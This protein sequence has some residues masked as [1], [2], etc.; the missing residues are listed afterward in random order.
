MSE[1]AA[2]LILLTFSVSPLTY[3]FNKQWTKS[4][5]PDFSV[6]KR[7]N[8][9]HLNIASG[10]LKN[11]WKG[12]LC[13]WRRLQYQTNVLKGIFHSTHQCSLHWEHCYISLSMGL[14]C[15]SEKAVD[16]MAVWT[17]CIWSSVPLE[18]QLTRIR[19]DTVLSRPQLLSSG[20]LSV[21]NC[22]MTAKH[23]LTVDHLVQ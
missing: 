1:Q 18:R 14:Q 3:L 8:T 20:H 12:C 15:W 19:F 2:C 17:L 23:T 7:D 22:N 21:R 13:H 11:Y 9:L 10:R 5:H 4:H 16:E 6:F